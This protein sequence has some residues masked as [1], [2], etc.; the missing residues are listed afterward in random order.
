MHY[1]GADSLDCPDAIL[2]S[3]QNFGQEVAQYKQMRVSSAFWI[4]LESARITRTAVQ[5]LHTLSTGPAVRTRQWFAHLA[6]APVKYVQSVIIWIR[7]ALPRDRFTRLSDAILNS[8]QNF[9]Q[10]VAQYITECPFCLLFGHNL[11]RPA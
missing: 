4:Q 3:D 10:E 1:Y 6:R 7:Y 2:N 8:D 5:S 11:N 9:S